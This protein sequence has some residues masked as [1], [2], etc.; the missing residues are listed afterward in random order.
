MKFKEK[1][2]D[3]NTLKDKIQENDLEFNLFF[4][5]K[6]RNGNYVSFSPNIDAQIYDDLLNLICDYIGQFTG[7][8]IVDYNPTGYKDETIES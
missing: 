6:L 8:T 7:K 5:R 2:M 1:V 4:T 3:I